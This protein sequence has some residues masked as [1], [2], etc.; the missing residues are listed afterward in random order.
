MLCTHTCDSLCTRDICVHVTF[1]IV[2][3]SLSLFTGN[4]FPYRYAF[5]TEETCLHRDILKGILQNYNKE[6]TTVYSLLLVVGV[7][8]ASRT[9]T[10]ISRS[11]S[12]R[13][14]SVW[15][16]DIDSSLSIVCEFG[17]RGVRVSLW[18]RLITCLQI[19]THY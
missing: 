8:W 16:L 2:L 7:S 12:T 3:T 4:K 13:I 15:P 11:Q 9:T 5:S 1:V 14:T 10:D 18:P 17:R 6:W 19:N